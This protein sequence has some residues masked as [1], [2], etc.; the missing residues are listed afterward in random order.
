MMPNE[1]FFRL[2]LWRESFRVAL[3]SARS[4]KS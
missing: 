2:Q 3:R 1:R 4:A